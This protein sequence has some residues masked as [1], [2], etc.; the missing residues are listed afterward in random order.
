MN[1]LLERHLILL[2]SQGVDTTWHKHETYI[3]KMG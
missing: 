2:A 3:M 1:G